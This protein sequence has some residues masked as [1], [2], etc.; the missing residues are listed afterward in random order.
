MP[1]INRERRSQLEQLAREAYP[2]DEYDTDE[3]RVFGLICE[4][5]TLNAQQ[6]IAA[7]PA[8]DYERAMILDAV[9]ENV[10]EEGWKVTRR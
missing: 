6:G 3:E 8:L 10:T 1:G 9:L 2:G 7:G 4:L 5:T